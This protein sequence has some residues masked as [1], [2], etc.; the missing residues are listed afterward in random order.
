MCRRHQ[1][2]AAKSERALIRRSERTSGEKPR[3]RREIGIIEPA[4]ICGQQ[5]HFLELA[6]RRRDRIAGLSE[7]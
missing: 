1:R 2:A 6:R 7:R 4:Q 5:G 3:C